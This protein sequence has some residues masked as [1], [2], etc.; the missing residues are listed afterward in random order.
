MRTPAGGHGWAPLAAGHVRG[1][2]VSR[3]PRQISNPLASSSIGSGSHRHRRGRRLRLLQ[4][5]ASEGLTV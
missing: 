2:R 4:P 5:C 3:R 1:H